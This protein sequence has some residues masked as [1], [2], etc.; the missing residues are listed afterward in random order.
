MEKQIVLGISAV[1]PLCT[2]ERW[3]E[4]T[5]LSVATVFSGCDRGFWPVVHVGKRVLIN[6]EAVRQ[7]AA[8]KAEEFT[9]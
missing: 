6:L 3:A 1:P 7:A 5:G 9:L 4:L 2:R 8:K